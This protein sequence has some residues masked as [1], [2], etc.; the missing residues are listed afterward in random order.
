[1]TK[2]ITPAH[3]RRAIDE[4]RGNV[5][6]KSPPRSVLKQILATLPAKQLDLAFLRRRAR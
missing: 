1:V 4:A 3:V 6:A 5:P 2:Q